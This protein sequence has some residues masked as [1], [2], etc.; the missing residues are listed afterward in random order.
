MKILQILDISDRL[1]EYDI[2]YTPAK[3]I[4]AHALADFLVE[5]SPSLKESNQEIW[6]FFVDGSV[7]RNGRGAGIIFKNLEEMKIKYVIQF[8]SSLQMT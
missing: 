3:A 6:N 5:L 1:S 8:E 2:R 4:K 7:S